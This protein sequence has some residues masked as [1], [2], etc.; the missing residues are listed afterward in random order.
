MLLPLLAL[1]ACGTPKS[2]DSTAPLPSTV[3]TDPSGDSGDSAAHDTAPQDTAPVDTSDTAVP[4]TAADTGPTDSGP[5]P[6]RSLLYPS[7][8]SPAFTDPS[9]AFLHDVSY[10]G[11]RA[12][13]SPLPVVTG[14]IFEVVS[15]GADASGA[16]DARAAIQAAIDAAGAAGGGVVH[17]PAGTYRCDDVL[18]VRHD[19]VVLRGDG[20]TATFVRFTRTSGMSDRAHLTF[21]GSL[22]EGADLVVARDLLTRSNVVE[23][24][25]A[26]GLSV[27]Q[28]VHVGWTITEAFIAEHGM[29]DTWVSFTG[30]WKPFFRRTITAIDTSVAP[31]RVTL[32]VPLRYAGKVRDGASLRPVSG[33]LTEVGVED[34]AVT[35][36]TTW[37]EA[38]ALDRS[39]AVL[40]DGVK[41]G[42]VHDLASYGPPDA[43][44][45]LRDHL[46]SGGIKV[47][48]SRRVTIDHTTMEEPQNRGG[49]GNGYLFEV[50]R[51]NEVLTVDST[52]RSGRHNFIQNWDFGT[53]GCVWLRTRSEGGRSYLG[54]WDPVGYPSYSEYHHSLAMANLVDQSWA[55][56]GW[57]GVNRQGESSGAGH[58]ATENVFWNTAGGGY[59]RSLQYGLG[60]VIGTDGMNLH[61]DPAEW[62]WNQSGEGT[63]PADWVEGI[64]AAA[65]LD[66]PSLFEDQRAR[67][68]ARAR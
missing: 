33:Y 2:G 44:D 37:S 49:G 51:S 39:H 42:W 56:D 11:Y 12:S 38:W 17:L 65:T 14:P 1:L 6:W 47:L 21:Q 31:A 4:D 20:P 19:A 23:V 54:D 27:G 55:S 18:V 15:Y 16:S 10:A 46:A 25:D 32:D 60:Y 58:S 35:T 52:A 30:Q 67:R 40:L 3:P 8:W 7:D 57:Q 36:V 28:E 29:T 45:L 41:D 62:D 34:L 61:T 43:P 48:N 22:R 68:L 24:T 13:E 50:S 9:G 63:D 26:S 64:D 53:S 59:L 66:P 5:V